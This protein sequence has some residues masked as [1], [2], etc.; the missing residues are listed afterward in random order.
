MDASALHDRF[1]WSAK[2]V[3]N[4]SMMKSELD[5][6]KIKEEGGAPKMSTILGDKDGEVHR[7]VI[8]NEAA[9]L[10]KFLLAKFI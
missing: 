7:W 5:E 1:L 10:P 2:L 9:I 8:G 3:F 6:K 4:E